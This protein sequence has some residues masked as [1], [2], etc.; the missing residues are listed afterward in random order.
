MAWAMVR[1]LLRGTTQS[2]IRIFGKTGWQELLMDLVDPDQLP[3]HWG[4][5]LVGK[6]GN[7]Y[8]APEVSRGDKFTSVS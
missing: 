2:K 7:P 1:P 3:K 8:F 4:G 5:T 6:D